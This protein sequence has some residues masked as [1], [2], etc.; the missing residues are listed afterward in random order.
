MKLDNT[1]L[2]IAAV[3]VAFGVYFYAKQKSNAD[4]FKNAYNVLADQLA[5]GQ[6]VSKDATNKG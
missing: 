3:L 1:Q 6:L 2:T 5:S 4:Q